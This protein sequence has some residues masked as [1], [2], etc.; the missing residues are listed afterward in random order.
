MCVNLF[1]KEIS[2]PKLELKTEAR[3]NLFNQLERT[4]TRLQEIINK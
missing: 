2:N 1:L 4:K 3:D